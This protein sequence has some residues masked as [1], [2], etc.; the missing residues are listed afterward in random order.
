MSKSLTL[1][2]AAAVFGLVVAAAGPAFAD[3]PRGPGMGGGQM[4]GGMMG[5]GQMGGGQMG[6]GQMGGGM[7]GGGQ[8]GGGMM[9][10]GQMGG[11]QMMDDADPDDDGSL[12]QDEIDKA[13]GERFAQFDANGDGV[14]DL[15]E[16]QALWLDAMRVRM[17]RGFQ[18]HDRDGDA[19]V[20]LE[21]F[22]ATTGN[23]A[24]RCDGQP[25]GQRRGSGRG[26][27]PN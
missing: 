16:Y 6:G 3:C 22:T 23:L 7:M 15:A 24:R 21:E 11:G 5:G 18:R 19:L 26:G 14:L 2:T 10:G 4:G 17:V 8:M 20:T 25:H 12:T 13:R 9:G 1:A 27:N